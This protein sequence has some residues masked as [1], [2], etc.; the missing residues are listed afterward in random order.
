MIHDSSISNI[1]ESLLASQ[2]NKLVSDQI[3]MTERIYSQFAKISK[4]ERMTLAIDE[5]YCLKLFDKKDTPFEKISC[6]PPLSNSLF[7]HLTSQLRHFYEETQVIS[8]DGFNIMTYLDF[9]LN[10]FDSTCIFWCSYPQISYDIIEEADTYYFTIIKFNQ[11]RFKRY[12]FHDGELHPFIKSLNYTWI[13]QY[14]ERSYDNAFRKAAANMNDLLGQTWDHINLLS[15]LKYE[16]SQNNGSLLFIGDEIPIVLLALETPVAL[17]EYRQIR[18]LLQMSRKEHFLLVNEAYMAIGFGYIEANKPIYRIDFLDHLNWKLYHGDEEFL[19]CTNLLPLLPS[20]GNSNE[21]LKIQLQKTFAGYDYDESFLV[22]TIEEAK[23]QRKG[24]MI[25]ITTKAEE[26]ANRLLSS[27]IK[28]ATLKLSTKQIKMVTGIDGAVIL[29]LKG[30]CHAVGTILDGLATDN[31]DSSRGARYNSALRYLNTQ[32]K[33]G[34]P[35]LIAVVS[36]DRYV[37]ILTTSKHS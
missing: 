10:Q 13:S 1:I 20:I 19:A 9:L 4:D 17:S 31:G 7:R 30:N 15:T 24:T 37:D 32:I 23:F 6:Y 11:A 34:N 2:E 5:V 21:K 12:L 18:K 36:E 22:Q 35:C 27:S 26:E 3:Q 14:K 25:V 8:E 29:D 16:G 28:V 33:A